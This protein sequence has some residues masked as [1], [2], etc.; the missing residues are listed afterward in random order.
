VLAALAA[1]VLAVR[2]AA[3]QRTFGTVARDFGAGLG[4]VANVWTAPLRADAG[5]WAGG[6]LVIGATA[7]VAAYDLQIQDWMREHPKSVPIVLLRP[8]RE[9]RDVPLVDLGS[10]KRLQ[11]LSGVL[12][13]A[14]FIADE[15]GLR[16]AGMGCAAVQQAQTIVHSI[17]TRAVSRTRPR[18]AP[19][20][21]Y[22]MSW[23]EGPWEEHSFYGGHAANAMACATFFA[24]RF[25][26][27]VAEPLLYALAI[28]VGVGRMAD[29][30]HW[31]S[32]TFIGMAYGHAAGRMIGRRSRARAERRAGTERVSRDDEGGLFATRGA[33]GEMRIG[34]RRT[35]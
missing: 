27:G 34:W 33:Y 11:P 16:D 24:E 9:S 1:G 19:D 21:P 10:G 28:G 6:L 3:A 17:G 22:R 8:F 4:D 12:Y 32:D 30:R 2:P 25:D 7:G 5:E 13:L 31:A 15:P 18:Q 26:L 35:F 23:G 20:D 14:G 29:E